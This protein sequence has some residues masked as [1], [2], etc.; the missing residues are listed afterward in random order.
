MLAIETR[1]KPGDCGVTQAKKKECPK[2]DSIVNLK[3]NN[4][5]IWTFNW[6]N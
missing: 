3:N 2:K 1:E 5:K 6:D 4:N